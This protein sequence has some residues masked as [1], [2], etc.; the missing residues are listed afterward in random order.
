MTDAQQL[1]KVLRQQA[2]LQTRHVQILEAQ[3][4]A[5]IACDR[6]AFSAL[7][8][9]HAGLL[10]RLERQEAE[11]RELMRDA[12]GEP[13]SLSALMEG[14]SDR[15]RRTLETIREGLRRTLEKAQDLSRRNQKLIQNELDYLAF[16]LDLFVEAG[17]SADTAYGGCG[18]LGGR[19]LLDRRA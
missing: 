8:E 13:C 14:C 19:L 1:I 9:E 2:T 6:K 17:R 18:Q 16:T 11:R 15:D 10:A 7:Q 4:R 3:Q 5:L 12:D